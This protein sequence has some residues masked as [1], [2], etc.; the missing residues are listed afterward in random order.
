MDFNIE[1]SHRF[2]FRPLR[3]SDQLLLEVRFLFFDKLQNVGRL[4]ERLAKDDGGDRRALRDRRHALHLPCSAASRLPTMNF[5]VSLGC[6]RRKTSA[7]NRRD[8]RA[9]GGTRTHKDR[10]GHKEKMSSWSRRF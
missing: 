6:G 2:T 9:G 3:T 4:R 7:L 5:T 1:H 10:E 8:Y